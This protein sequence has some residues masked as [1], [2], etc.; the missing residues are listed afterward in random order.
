MRAGSFLPSILEPRRWV[1]QALLAVIMEAY[2]YGVPPQS[3]C[4]GVCPGL[5]ERHLQDA[6]ESH[7]S[8][9]RPAGAGLSESA[10]T[11]DRLRL[12][13]HGRYLSPRQAG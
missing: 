10:I 4:L 13:L 8:G 11:G 9:D 6:G 1:E 12:R 3:G 7:L 2:I 5:S